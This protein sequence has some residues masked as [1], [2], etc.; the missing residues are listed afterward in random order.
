MNEP[1]TAKARILVVDDDGDI[2][3]A[4]EMALKRRGYEVQTA[5][6]GLEALKRLESFTPDLVI[7]DLVLPGM[8]GFAIFEGIRHRM[9][10]VVPFVFMTATSLRISRDLLRGVPHLML[11]KPL[12]FDALVARV[13]QLLEGRG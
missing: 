13:G 4:V 2:C 10:R 11:R 5:M 3:A 9:Q 7:L 1:T 12:D 8:D 6:T